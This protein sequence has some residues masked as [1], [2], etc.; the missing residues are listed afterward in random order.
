[1]KYAK[2]G[3]CQTHYHRWWRTG[4]PLGLKQPLHAKGSDAVTWQGDNITYRTAHT[5]L[6]RSR[7][8]ASQHNCQHCGNQAYQWAYDK[9]DPDEK[10]GTIRGW[11]DADHEVV[12]SA[13][14]E[15]YVPLCRSCH[16]SFDHPRKRKTHCHKGHPFDERNTY[17]RADGER[18]CRRCAADR[19]ARKRAG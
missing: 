13:K 11:G 16:R 7:G 19:A 10:R 17:I 1:M 6:T 12:Y 4:D 14:L 5:R 3:W 18:N 15:H 2:L 8:K 9:Q